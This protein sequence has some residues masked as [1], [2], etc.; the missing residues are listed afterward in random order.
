MHDELPRIASANPIRNGSGILDLTEPLTKHVRPLAEQ[1]RSGVPHEKEF[2]LFARFDGQPGLFVDIGA[3]VGQSAVSFRAVNRSM[4]ILS[5]EPNPVLEPLLAWVR[6]ELLRDFEFRM[7]GCSDQERTSTLWIPV[8]D[9]AYVTPLAS[10]RPEI[11]DRAEDR[12][13]LLGFS[14][15]GRYRLAEVAIR[16]IRL[17]SLGLTPAI[18]K[19][20]AEEHEMEC[21]RGMLETLRRARPLCMFEHNSQTP[22]IIAFLAE[23]GYRPYLYD[24]SRR[25]LVPHPAPVAAVNVFYVPDDTARF[26][27]LDLI[28]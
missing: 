21:L 20:D 6:D 9:N 4:P 3:N 8:V 7:L 28:A 27:Q 26:R 16:T 17:D 10:T 19:V 22:A 13:R 14:L 1:F 15:D 11:F 5:F 18:V 12:D 25:R 23:S 2:E 24:P